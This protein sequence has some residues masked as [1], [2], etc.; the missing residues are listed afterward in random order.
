MNL[1]MKQ[2]ESHG[3][4]ACGCQGGGQVGKGRVGSWD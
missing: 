1:S 4:Q 3:E 2:K